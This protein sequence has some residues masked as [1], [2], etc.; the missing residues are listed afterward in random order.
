MTKEELEERCAH[1]QKLLRLQDWTV[2][3]RILRQWDMEREN[4]MAYVLRFPPKR[5]A[6]ICFRDSIDDEPH[7]WPREDM[8]QSLIH[9]LIH[10]HI[11]PFEPADDAPEWTAMEQAIHSLTECIYRLSRPQ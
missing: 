7:G 5:H 8:E 6:V 1:W 10:C 3:I 4:C 2:E 9:E 11:T